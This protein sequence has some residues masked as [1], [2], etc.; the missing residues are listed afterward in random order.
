[1]PIIAKNISESV[2]ARAADDVPDS[3]EMD[4]MGDRIFTVSMAVRADPIG[5]N[6]MVCVGPLR[7]GRSERLEC[8]GCFYA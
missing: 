7:F 1:V 8:L 5:M 2:P 4:L 3:D 6:S